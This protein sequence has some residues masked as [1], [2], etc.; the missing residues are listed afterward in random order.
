MARDDPGTVLGLTESEAT[1]RA[2]AGRANVVATSTSRSLG[3]IIRANVLTRFN[4][5][6]GTL[7]L[8]VLVFRIY[9]DALFG[10]VLVLNAL[11][12]IVQELRAKRTLDR[13][14]L[15]SAPKARVVRDGVEREVRLE[16]VVEGDLLV[17]TAGDQVVVDGPLLASDGLEVDES[18]LTGE[19]EPIVHALGDEL[20]SGSLVVGGSGRFVAE[21]VGADAYAH[22]LAAQARRFDLVRSEL[23]DGVNQILRL[24]SWML[25][26]TAAL[27]ISSQA[28]AND[29][30]TAAVQGSVAG[31]VAMVPEG[32]VLLTSLAFA[33]GVVRLGRRGVLTQELAAL[34]GL[35]RVDVVC[36]DKTGTLTDGGL[37]ALD[38][39]PLGGATDEEVR[40]ALGAMA[41]AEA[42]PNASLAAIGE[43]HPPPSGWEATSAVAFSSARKWSATTFAAQGTW[44]LGAPDVLLAS[45]DDAAQVLERVET[46]AAQG[47]RVLLLAR[48]EQ[49]P[50]GEEL[51]GAPLP[52]ALVVLGEQVRPDASDTLAY[53]AEQ[54][55]AIK[56]ISGDHPRTVGAVAARVGVLGGD[57]PVD[58]RSLPEDLDALADVMERSTVFG[59]VTPEQKRAM[60]HALQRR[61]H[62]VAMT[63]DGVNDVLALKD[64]DVGVAMGSGSAA[65]RA[66]AR[67]VLLESSFAVLPDVVAE[68]RRVIANVERVANLF[69]TKTVYAMVLALVVGATRVPF[70]FL[71]RHLT[72]IGALTIGVPGFFLAL[73]PNSTRAQSGFLERVLR[74]AVPSGIVAGT[75]TLVGYQLAR[76]RV[77]LEEARTAATAILFLI[78]LWVL[79]ILARPIVAWRAALLCTMVGGFVVVLGVPA[80]RDFYELPLPDLLEVAEIVAIAGAGM[81][82]IEMG[83]RI[84]RWVSPNK[85]PGPR[86]RPGRHRRG[87]GPPGSSQDG[88]G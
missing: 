68:G 60:V 41:A 21:R 63:G 11:I 78:A 87:E 10:I 28:L 75:A 50:D 59:R 86:R 64:A 20:R 67:F 58:A 25:L 23:R 30:L 17:L 43:A 35:A 1:A 61:G 46:L 62:T 88:S 66:V 24:V 42:H 13:L 9:A 38:A 73:A 3:E 33:V 56:V 5:I 36:L 48:S 70:P 82:A 15:L 76:Q 32:L 27:L 26:P 12:G 84:S 40:G 49:A 83:W 4:A 85:T 47:Q 29:S 69:L 80:L 31:L 81:A 54:G 51:R 6:L 14:A 77:P 44:L 22:Q 72:V 19:S 57:D 55:V 53:F 52:A 39:E 65:T 18:L 7:L 74:F 8:V 45:L 34:E 2:A 16:E 79:A 71:P 37:V